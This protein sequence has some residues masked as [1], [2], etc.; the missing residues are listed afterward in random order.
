MRLTKLFEYDNLDKAKA[1]ILDQIAGLDVTDEDQIKLLDKIFRILNSEQSST[2]INAAFGNPKTGPLADE[3]WSDSVTQGHILNVAKIISDIDTDYNSLMGFLK[4]LEKGKA[5]DVSVFDKKESTFSEL[6]YGDPIAVKVLQSLMMYGKDKKRAGAGEFALAMLSPKIKMAPGEGDLLING[7]TVELK[8]ETSNGGGRMGTN[9]PPRDA[10]IKVLQKYA[11][12]IPEI[13]AAFPDGIKGKSANV[14]VFVKD[15]LDKYL[16]VG[17]K[18]P[19]GGNNT[20]IR[21]AIGTEIFDL[22]FGK[23]YADIMGKAF[24]QPNPTV[25]KNA[26]ITQNY[27]WYKARD[28]FSLFVV[29]S[30]KSERLTMIRKGEEMAE[31]FANGSLSGGSASFIHSGQ[32][33]ECFAQ[34]NIPY[35]K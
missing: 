20:Q 2:T 21:Q 14:S 10:Q 1:N 13:I 31:A 25:S 5:L 34:M 26:M 15:Y 23:P 12:H 35:A 8:A 9:G 19:A 28:K 6:C 30:F 11:E 4:K 7:G 22:T 24:G 33:S 29:M 17:G 3:D 32:P 27:E 16:P 18:S